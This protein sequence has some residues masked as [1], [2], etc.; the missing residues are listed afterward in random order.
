ML[1]KQKKFSKMT[2]NF[3]KL[4]LFCRSHLKQ[5]QMIL[6]ESNNFKFGNY[7]QVD[8]KKTISIQGFIRLG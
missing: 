3:L 8:L 5:R 2:D 1:R 4:T 6:T 7:C